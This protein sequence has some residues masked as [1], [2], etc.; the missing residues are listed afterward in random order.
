MHVYT[1]THAHTHTHKHTQE[2]EE[3]PHFWFVMVSYYYDTAGK[4]V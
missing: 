4:D 3:T 2:R 1:D